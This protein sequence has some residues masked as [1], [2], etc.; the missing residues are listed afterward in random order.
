MQFVA[1]TSIG[2]EQL[3]QQ[4]LTELGAEVNKQRVGAV[5][6][7]ADSLTAQK[8]CLCTRLATRIMLVLQQGSDIEDKTSLYN[9]AR[10]QPWQEFFG[11]DQ[12]FAVEFSGTNRQLKNTQF[13]A[14]V[15]KDAICDYFY[16]LYERR[17]SVSKETPDVRMVAK[18]NRDKLTLYIDY[19]GPRLSQ[20]GYRSAQ[21]KAPLKEHLAAALVMRS[22]WLEDT[23]KPLFDPTCGSG[24]LLIE[25]ALMAQNKAPGLSREGFA[26]E[27]LPSFRI[28]KFKELKQSIK[29]QVSLDVKPWLIGRDI[30]PQVIKKAQENAANAGV[31]ECIDFAVGDL[32]DMKAPAKRPGVLLANL[33]YGER[34]GS[35]AEIVA[36]Y[37]QM[38]HQLKQHFCH[39][40]AAL[41]ISEPEMLKL[42]KLV[43]HK[44]YKFKNGPLDTLLALYDI[45]EQQ[46]QGQSESKTPLHFEESVAFANRLKKNRQALKKWLKSDEITAYRL[47]DADI[48]EYNVA[49]DVYQNSA[50]IYEY[51]APKNIDP[52]VAQKRLQDVLMLT[53][54]TLE[55][56]PGQVALKERRKQKGDS[57]YQT[58]GS[59][60]KTMVITEYGAK[61][62]VNL[63]DYLDTGIFLDHRL[64]RKLVRELSQGK[65][66]LNLFAY[67]GTASVQAALGGAKSVTT[68]DMSKTYLQWAQRNFALNNLKSPRY[69]FEQGDCIEWL[70]RTRG[71]YDLIFLDPPTFSNSKRMRDSFDVQRDHVTLIKDAAKLLAKQGTLLFSNNKRGFKM[72][73]DALA[74]QGLQCENITEQTQSPDF[75]R[76]K[77]IHNAWVIR[78]G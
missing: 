46:T 64:A 4:E 28:A 2:I 15:I 56:A 49:V 71:E 45:T 33:P 41:L 63:F 5:E 9:F 30:N 1:S 8:I 59:Q 19:S 37:R 75:A 78:H 23:S 58:Q 68:V 27:R 76:N 40:R 69:R 57:Q 7:T 18:L 50:V 35:M 67:T 62:E 60:G 24:T 32:A 53:C 14:L 10:F 34:L 11:P 12:S 38:G 29:D 54:E 20:R 52:N 22:G 73:V 43:K 66:V 65:R 77:H 26:F 6:F 13:G 36:L 17:P 16:D 21:G 55:I 74:L 39:W 61:F 42:F 47:Y 25:A 72:D 51:A 44:Q 3:L 31:S 70:K 48:P